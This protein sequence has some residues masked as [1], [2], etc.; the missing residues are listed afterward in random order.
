MVV[1]FITRCLLAMSFVCAT[2][3]QAQREPAMLTVQEAR[4]LVHEA[5]S[6]QTKRLPG[7]TLWLSAEE[8]AKPSRCLTFDVL[9]SNPGP[10]SV[11]VGF[12]S[13]DRRT[14]EVWMP[15]VCRHVTNASLRKLQQAIRK[16]LGVTE[17]EYNQAL[18]HGP[19]CTPDTK[20][21]KHP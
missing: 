19:C 13:V 12:W 16:R 3:A 5:L 11:H 7:L 8:E 9:W 15:L 2:Y 1:R 20:T 6:K 10:G 18:K 14:G 17:T 4:D 21:R